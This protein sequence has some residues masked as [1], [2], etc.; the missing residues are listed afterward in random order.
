M[1][2]RACPTRRSTKTD[3][4]SSGIG[5]AALKPGES[6]ATCLLFSRCDSLAFITEH[7]TERSAGWKVCRPQ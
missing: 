4:G 1:F 7:G 3:V 6:Y 2:A 5:S